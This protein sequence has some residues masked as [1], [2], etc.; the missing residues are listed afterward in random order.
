LTIMGLHIA[1]R[2][3]LRIL[4]I[5]SAKRHRVQNCGVYGFQDECAGRPAL[6][7]ARQQSRKRLFRKI[8][9]SAELTLQSR[10]MTDFGGFFQSTRAIGELTPLKRLGQVAV[11]GPTLR[12][13]LVDALE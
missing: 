5:S 1:F 13:V 2:A 9:L 8:L 3:H 12:G 7:P 6:R 4:I 10:K 11:G